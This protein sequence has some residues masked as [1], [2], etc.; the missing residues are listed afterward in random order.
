MH[1]LRRFHWHSFHPRLQPTIFW[2][3]TISARFILHLREC[4]NHFLPSRA[5]INGGV[6]HEVSAVLRQ[7]VWLHQRLSRRSWVSADGWESYRDGCWVSRSAGDVIGKNS[8]SRPTENCTERSGNPGLALNAHSKLTNRLRKSSD[9]NC[10]YWCSYI[11]MYILVQHGT[12]WIGKTKTFTP[13]FHLVVE[14]FEST[15]TLFV[16]LVKN[17]KTAQ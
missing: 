10:F 2:A 17:T 1:D 16:S 7:W 5:V 12:Y 8:N 14:A 11:R 9:G 13:T 4:L 6:R 3:S 15:T